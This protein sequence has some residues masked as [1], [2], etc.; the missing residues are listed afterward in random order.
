[1][2][3]RRLGRTGLDVPELCLGTMT[4]GSMADEATS[5]R[6]LEMAWDAGLTFID[7]AEVYPVPPDPKW[8]GRSEEICAI[9]LKGRSRDGVTIAT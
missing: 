9:W 7:T 2:R 4:F 3:T 8:A 5:L 1:V 6:C